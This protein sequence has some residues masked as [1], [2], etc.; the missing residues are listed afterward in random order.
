MIEKSLSTWLVPGHAVAIPPQKRTRNLKRSPKHFHESA[1]GVVSS[2]SLSAFLDGSSYEI[3]STNASC[4]CSNASISRREKVDKRRSVCVRTMVQNSAWDIAATCWASTGGSTLLLSAAPLFS[5]RS[6]LIVLI[7]AIDIVY[8]LAT[9]LTNSLRSFWLIW[10]S[11]AWINVPR[12]L[13]DALTSVSFTA[14]LPASSTYHAALRRR[15]KLRQL[16]AGQHNLA[17]ASSSSTN[18]WYEPAE[19]HCSRLD[20]DWRMRPRPLVPPTTLH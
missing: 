16:T 5:S 1:N 18:Y 3:A 11:F 4:S 8:N 12:L 20:V 2:W 6:A 13:L 17:F 15:M 9:S 7:P 14:N 10:S 19:P